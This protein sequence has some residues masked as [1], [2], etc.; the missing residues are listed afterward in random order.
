MLEFLIIIRSVVWLQFY[1][2]TGHP[3]LSSSSSIPP[4]TEYIVSLRK[5]RRDQDLILP[6]ESNSATS[7]SRDS[8]RS[9]HTSV[10]EGSI[11]TISC[12]NLVH[13]PRCCWPDSLIMV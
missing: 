5:V 3:D 11:D 2:G 1:E 6:E 12:W 7:F 4:H 9:P 8:H 10:R 13:S